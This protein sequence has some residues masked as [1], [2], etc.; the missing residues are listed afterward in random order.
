MDPNLTNDILKIFLDKGLLA[1]TLAAAGYYINRS[2]ERY[3]A[4]NAYNQKLAE[5]RI[6]AYRTI[7]RVLAEQALHVQHIVSI[8]THE[9][10]VPPRTDE[11]R[12]TELITAYNELAASYTQ[13]SAALASNLVF[14]SLDTADLL[15]NFQGALSQFRGAFQRGPDDPHAIQLLAE[16]VCDLQKQLPRLQTAIATELYEKPFG[17]AATLH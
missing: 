1:L 16:A 5:A 12:I 15:A 17:S 10:E 9:N 11:Q 7:G 13:E 8:L 14:C 6:D 4:A 2:L 3:R